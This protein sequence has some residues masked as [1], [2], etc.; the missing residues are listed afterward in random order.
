METSDTENIA[1]RKKDHHAAEAKAFG[2][3]EHNKRKRDESTT[4]QG[5]RSGDRKRKRKRVECRNPF[6]LGE[7]KKKRDREESHIKA[8]N[9]EGKRKKTDGK[10][11][12]NQL[13]SSTHKG[14]S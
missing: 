14:I 11:G 5:V 8:P 1:K 10:D 13:G 7:R 2:K 6:S 9:A 12:C 3:V 4:I